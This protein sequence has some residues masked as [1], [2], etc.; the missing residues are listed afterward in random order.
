MKKKILIII[1]IV[2]FSC[3]FNES[4]N[5]CDEKY[6]NY[7]SSLLYLKE[8]KLHEEGKIFFLHKVASNI[9][10]LEDQSKIKSEYQGNL[11]GRTRVSN[12]DIENWENWLSKRCDSIKNIRY[13]YR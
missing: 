11:I 8:Y 13:R 6:K 3:N 1:S 2:L 7:K 5:N 9:G 4:N 10:F 12:K